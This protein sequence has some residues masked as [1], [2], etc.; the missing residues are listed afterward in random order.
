MIIII[1]KH[2]FPIVPILLSEVA[3][4]SSL[5][6]FKPITNPIIARIIVKN[7]IP[8]KSIAKSISDVN[9]A[10][11][12]VSTEATMTIMK[13]ISETGLFIKYYSNFFASFQKT[14]ISA[15]EQSAKALPCAK[16]FCSI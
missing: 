12:I 10:G 11:N 2:I 9:K 6:Y 16:I 1:N 8:V 15:K 3:L 13:I 14:S 5:L 7:N 4:K